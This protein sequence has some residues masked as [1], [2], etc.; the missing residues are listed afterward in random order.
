MQNSSA[1]LPLANLPRRKILFLLFTRFFWI[2]L[3]VIGGGLAILLAAERLF[4]KKYHWLTE[5]ELFEMYPVYQSV[6][7]LIAGNVAIYVGS[8]A[9]GW[10]GALCALTGVVLPSFIVIVIIAGIFHAAP[11]SW[12]WL[13]GAFIGIRTVMAALTSALMVKLWKKS[14]EPLYA[15]P[16]MILTFAGMTFLHVNPGILLVGSMLIGILAVYLPEFHRKESGLA[17]IAG[18]TL[19]FMYFGL[20]CVG[21]GSMLIS[22][23][24]NEL[25]NTRNW[26]TLQELADFMAIS[27][28]TPGP[29]GINLATFIGFRRAGFFGAMASTAGLM[30]PSYICMLLVLKFLEK[31]KQ[32]RLVQG[33]L[34]GMR[35]AS[36]GLMLAVWLVCLELSVFTASVPWKYLIA[37]SAD[38]GGFGIRYLTLPLFAAAFYALRKERCSI[39][40]AI[41]SGAAYGALLCR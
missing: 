20:L 15:Y 27:Q 35:P 21:G 40:C 18:I 8:R 22:F 28:I 32:S 2:A 37:M 24:I 30:L 13:N 38:T 7:G 23:Y 3:T 36:L 33:I 11:V 4:V 19:L 16:V 17:T 9:C 31:W 1:P 26:M 34:T 10:A 5:E 14:M 39:M 25:V 12:P 6:P 29:I 41:F